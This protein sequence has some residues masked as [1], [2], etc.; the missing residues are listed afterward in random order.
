MFTFADESGMEKEETL[1]IHAF[2]DRNVLEVFVNERTVI[3]T[4]IYTP[5][6]ESVSRLR[7]FAELD[8]S[9]PNLKHAPAVLLKADLWDGLEAS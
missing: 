9:A 6:V 3:S 1:R 7:F 2:L 8:P 5:C 4:R